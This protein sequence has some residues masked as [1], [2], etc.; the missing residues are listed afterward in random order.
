MRLDSKRVQ[1]HRIAGEAEWGLVGAFRIPC[2]R[3]GA[4]LQVIAS[5]GEGW[6]HVSVSLPHRCPTWDEMAFIKSLFFFDT[7][8]VVQFHPAEAFYVNCHPYCLHL[9]RPQAYEVELPP[10]VLVGPKTAH[11]SEV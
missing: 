2:P 5:D 8:S 3:T 11:G 6:D 1:A 4:A 9:W 10:M 7:E